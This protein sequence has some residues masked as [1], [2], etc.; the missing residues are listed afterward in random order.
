MEKAYVVSAPG[1]D[2]DENLNQLARQAAQVLTNIL[3]DGIRLGFSTGSAVAT[4]LQ[5]FKAVQPLHVQV[6]PLHGIKEDLPGN[7]CNFL[8]ILIKQLSRDIITFPAPWLMQSLEAS[9]LIVQEKT[10]SSTL[11]LA[12]SADVGLIGIGGLDENTSEIFRNGWISPDEFKALREAGAVGEIC[13]K[14]FDQEGQVLDIPIN[15][16]IIAINLNSLRGFDTV[17]AVAGS[18]NK[19]KA[20]LAALRGRLINILVTDSDAAKEILNLADSRY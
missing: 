2:C 1:I 20:I 14:F 6:V 10:V 7:G 5:C 16:R 12:E 11:Q 9:Q 13:G 17:L 3:H 19:A 4:T 15:K 18:K 8:H